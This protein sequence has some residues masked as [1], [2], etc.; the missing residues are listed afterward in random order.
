MS[1][2][3]TGMWIRYTDLEKLYGYLPGMA[4]LAQ[5]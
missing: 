3:N 5:H 2:P 4:Q 1:N